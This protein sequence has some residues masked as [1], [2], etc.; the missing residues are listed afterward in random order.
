MSRPSAVPIVPRW[1]PSAVAD[2]VF[3]KPGQYLSLASG[4]VLG[5]AQPEDAGLDQSA[6]I[7]KRPATFETASGPA[8]GIEAVDCRT[9]L[10]HDTAVPINGDPAHRVGD[11][12]ADRDRKEWGGFDRAWL[13]T[14]RRT[15]REKRGQPSFPH[16]VVVAGHGLGGA[17]A[18]P[19]GHHR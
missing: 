7:S 8:C 6:D 3:R 17:R 4:G 12:G 5:D 16:C 18:R 1:R 13:T 19:P 9:V 10:P 2:S 15:G 14:A 11:A